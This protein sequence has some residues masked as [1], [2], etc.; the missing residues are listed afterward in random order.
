M[1]ESK[2][3]NNVDQIRELI[4]GPQ[5]KELEGRFEALEEEIREQEQ[6]LQKHFSELFDK[7]N[8]ETQR[9]LEVLDQKIDDLAEASRKYRTK[10]KELIDVTDENLQTQI[11]NLKN[12]I[13]NKLKVSRENLEDEDR[14]LRKDLESVKERL[15]STLRKEI[16]AI[17]HDKVSR[18]AMAEMLLDV[19][20]KLQGSDL[21]TLMG[22]G[23]A[24][25]NLQAI[26]DAGEQKTES[27]R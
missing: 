7:L 16:G 24:E 17:D 22:A 9:S 19:A 13:N 21:Q 1:A 4:F 6:R 3:G 25:A 14:K 11:R 5:M 23:G 20:M 12:E 8:R 15:E 10:L 2:A 18:N 26:A 27:A